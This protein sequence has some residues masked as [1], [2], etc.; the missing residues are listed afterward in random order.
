MKLLYFFCLFLL[1]TSCKENKKYLIKIT[2]KTVVID[3]TINSAEKNNNIIKP[4]REKLETEM[5]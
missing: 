2:G 5:Q 1:L 4:C 3:S